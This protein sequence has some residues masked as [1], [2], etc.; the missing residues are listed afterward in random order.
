MARPTKTGLDYFP[1]DVDFFSDIKT[2]ILKSRYGNDGLIVYLYLIC[3]I[4]KN[5]YYLKINDDFLYIVSDDLNMSANKIGQ[6]LNFLLERSLFSDK[7][8][9]SDKVLTSRGIQKRFQEAIKSRASKTPFETSKFWVLSEEETQSYI[10][11]T[12]NPSY[13]EKNPSYSEKNPSYSKN[14]DTK[15]SKVN[16]SKVNKSKAISENQLQSDIICK[17]IENSEIQNLLFDYIDMRKSIK[18]KM[19][20]NALILAIKKLKSISADEAVQKEIVETAIVSNWKSFYPLNKKPE[21]S[22][23]TQ[24]ARKESTVKSFSFEK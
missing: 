12:H 7:L 19:T 11:V 5:G 21:T 18:T 20:T 15:E 16:K 2:K 1:F 4:Y 22:T 23:K 14:N 13:S 3:E 17:E 8:F 10:K 9:K 6:I 24:S